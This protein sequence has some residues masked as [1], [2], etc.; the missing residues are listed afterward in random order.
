MKIM[1]QKRDIPVPGWRNDKCTQNG[2]VLVFFNSV[3]NFLNISRRDG[4]CV[5]VSTMDPTLPN[6]MVRSSDMV[7]WSGSVPPAP[8]SR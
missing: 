7:Y 6:L 2:L 1:Y 4:M 3:P 5:L 8:L